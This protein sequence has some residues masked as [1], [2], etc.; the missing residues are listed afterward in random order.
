MLHNPVFNFVG[1][2]FLPNFL[3]GYLVPAKNFLL[4]CN[5]KMKP[6]TFSLDF[7]NC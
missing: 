4:V 3:H 7:C 2:V 1:V 6:F 5:F